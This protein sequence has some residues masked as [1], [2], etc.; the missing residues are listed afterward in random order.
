VDVV[1]GSQESYDNP[2][3]INHFYEKLLLLKD[4]MNTTTGRL[5][6]EQRQIFLEEFLQQFWMEVGTN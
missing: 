2:N 6:A 5:L 4:L 1:P 3:T